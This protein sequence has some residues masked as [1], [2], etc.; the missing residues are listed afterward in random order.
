MPLPN[1]SYGNW[2]AYVIK[3]DTSSFVVRSFTLGTPRYQEKALWCWL[4]AEKSHFL[5]HKRCCSESNVI[6]GH[7]KSLALV[8]A[9][10]EALPYEMTERKRIG[11][12]HSD[13]CD[14][15]PVERG[16]TMPFRQTDLQIRKSGSREKSS[17]WDDVRP[18]HHFSAL[19]VGPCA[20]DVYKSVSIFTYS[21]LEWGKG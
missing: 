9:T 21:V 6:G 15:R 2:Y 5:N 4:T 3:K 16:G 1:W 12:T 13:L 19:V 7:G 10:T 18:R 17:Q 20:H 8:A 11:P 14:R